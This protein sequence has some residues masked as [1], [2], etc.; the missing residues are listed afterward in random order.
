MRLSVVIP[1]YNEERSIETVV[2]GVEDELLA[3]G[4]SFEILVVDDASTD[5]TAQQ[6]EAT[7]ASVLRH[8]Q[9]KG[10]GRSIK[11]G[12]REAQFD[13]IAII[14][15]DGQHNPRDLVRLLEYAEEFDMVIG[16]RRNYASSWW[17]WPGKWVLRTLCQYL[18]KADIPDVNSGLRIFK[19]H[20]IQ[21]YMH[22]CSNKFSFTTSSTLAFLADERDIA[23]I[24]IEAAKRE[25][26]RSA[27]TVKTGFRTLLLVLQTVL[28]FHPF[29]FFLPINCV[30]GGV[31]LGY[32]LWDLS[33]VNISD[34]AVLL[35]VTTIL[36]FFFSLISDQIAKLRRE[37][38][39]K[40]L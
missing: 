21:Q 13:Y 37:I 12:I 15:A 28:L 10:Y 31:A 36:V 27:V 30:I 11:D 2:R 7:S 4:H 5:M 23:Y 19:K 3:T 16:A 32:L 26:G 9:N 33:H 1:A 20:V 18:A 40:D 35:V 14:D 6:A 29:R 8:K 25:Q 22:L 17:R 38:Q 39:S 24:P 34:T